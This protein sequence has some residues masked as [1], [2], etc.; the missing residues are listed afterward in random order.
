LS[1]G[2]HCKLS[3]IQK[4]KIFNGKKKCVLETFRR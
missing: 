4:E 3:S 2:P 1:H